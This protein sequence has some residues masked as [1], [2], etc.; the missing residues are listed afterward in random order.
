M[1][2][3]LLASP[4]DFRTIGLLGVVTSVLLLPAFLK[5]HHP[6][7]V[8]S[9]NLGVNIFFLTGSPP[10]WMLLTLISLSISVL[11]WILN[12]NVQFPHVPLITWT[13]LFFGLVVVITAKITGGI[14]LRAW[15]GEAYGGKRYFYILF[16]ILGYFAISSQRIPPEKIN[17]YLGFFFLG[18]LTLAISNLTYALGPSFYWLFHVFPVEFALSHAAADW[19]GAEMTRLTGLSFAM[20]GVYSYLLARFG[21]REILN[22]KKPWRL[23]IWVGTIII[24]LSGGFRSIIVIFGLMFVF[25]FLLEGLSKTRFVLLG[26]I[27][28]CLAFGGL[29]LVADRLPLSVQRTLSILPLPIDSA[30]KVDAD[31]T[32]TWRLEMWKLVWQ[33][34]VPNHWL[35]GKGYS[36]KPLDLYLA[37]QSRIRGLSDGLEGVILA[38]DYHSG[39]L[40]LLVPFGIFGVLAFVFFSVASA[41]VLYQNYRYGTPNLRIVNTMLLATFLARQV[42]FWIIFGAISS[43]LPFF[44]GLVGLGVALNGG[45]RKREQMEAETSSL[46]ESQNE[47]V[48][49]S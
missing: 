5:W 40:S 21:L 31:A 25:Q 42:F 35:L 12:K 27:A 4:L 46:S 49:V 3:Y 6:L 20:V 30:V 19:S 24:S 28:S 47:P 34:E 36:I 22:I 39:P 23:A 7:L 11:T 2:G 16:A 9:W 15:G 44:V 26:A 1:L 8:L 32:S 45:V 10:L 33:A 43:D 14:G 48:A 38:G 37:E 17:M 41:W 13:L 29:Y 18:T